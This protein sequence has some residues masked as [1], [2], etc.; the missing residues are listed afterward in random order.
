MATAQQRQRAREDLKA[1]QEGKKLV[2]HT[3]KLNPK[4]KAKRHQAQMATMLDFGK[5]VRASK[6]ARRFIPSAVYDS[7]DQLW[8]MYLRD[9]VQRTSH[10]VT[11]NFAKEQVV[12]YEDTQVGGAVTVCRNIDSFLTTLVLLN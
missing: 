4:Q 5:A 1:Q 8:T 9:P 3:T 11:V 2:M 6:Q 12:V 7:G 10:T